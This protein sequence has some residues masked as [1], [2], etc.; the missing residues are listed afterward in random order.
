[1][2]NSGRG[3]IQGGG[4]LRWVLDGRRRVGVRGV[5]FSFLVVV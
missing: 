2:E 1:M 4:E 3:G 5:D